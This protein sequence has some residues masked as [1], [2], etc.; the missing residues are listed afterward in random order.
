MHK[1][2]DE[3]SVSQRIVLQDTAPAQEENRKQNKNGSK[4]IRMNGQEIIGE[5]NL[6]LKLGR[7]G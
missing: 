1:T 3:G 7:S 5:I 2:V 4:G 6:K